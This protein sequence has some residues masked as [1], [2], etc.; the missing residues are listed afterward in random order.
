MTSE[1]QQHLRQM[2]R[3][4]PW[5]IT[6]ATVSQMQLDDSCCFSRTPLELFHQ[7]FSFIFIL[8]CGNEK[9]TGRGDTPTHCDPIDDSKDTCFIPRNKPIQE[10]AEGFKTEPVTQET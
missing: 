4:R 5:S 8:H 1:T 2:E 3:R 9:L 6:M 7:T 10:T